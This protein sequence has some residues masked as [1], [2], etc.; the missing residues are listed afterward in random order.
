MN[1]QITYLNPPGL[2]KNPAF[3]QA[4]VVTGPVTTIYVGGQNALDAEGKIVGKGDIKAQTEK[5]LRN[6]ETAL[7]AAG[8]GLENVVKWNVLI[9]QDQSVH[10]GFEAFQKV[11]GNRPNPPAITGTIV[12][13]FGNP[14]YL[15]EIDAVAVIPDK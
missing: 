12:P 10:A 11:W 1:P 15:V 13:A 3:T 4:V 2:Y 5:A 8:A 6:L 9:R 14:D 7:Q